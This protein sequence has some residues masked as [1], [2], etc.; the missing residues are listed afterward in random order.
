MTE[1]HTPAEQPGPPVKHRVRLP[2]FVSD[3]EI[4]LGN[5]VKK[6]TSTI[7]IKTCGGCQRRAE[8]L[9]RWMSFT[10]RGSR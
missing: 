10:G 2:G 1:Q 3:E 5:V 9:N 7:G 8:A 4:G 6:V